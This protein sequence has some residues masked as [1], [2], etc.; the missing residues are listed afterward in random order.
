[1]SGQLLTGA[2]WRH[3][4][5]FFWTVLKALNKLE[6]EIM[7]LSAH[8]GGDTAA[9]LVEVHNACHAGIFPG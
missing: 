9:D 1:M 6:L 5:I 7:I 4:G 2:S 8:L 3:G